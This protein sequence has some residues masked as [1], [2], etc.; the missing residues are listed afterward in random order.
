ME[1]EGL[2]ATQKALQETLSEFEEAAVVSLN[3]HISCSFP[4]SFSF[5]TSVSFPLP[6]GVFHHLR[7][8]PVT[9]HLLALNVTLPSI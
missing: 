3:G 4:T 7:V 9:S 1:F 8:W 5:R 6:K 2:I